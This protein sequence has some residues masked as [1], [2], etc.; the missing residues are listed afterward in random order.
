MQVTAGGLLFTG[1]PPNFIL[2]DMHVVLYYDRIV[3][4]HTF[5]VTMEL[6]LSLSLSLSLPL[7][8]SLALILRHV[9][10]L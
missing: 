9:V 2:V 1:P 8:Y 5:V 6:H 3:Q 7:F 10:M 4:C